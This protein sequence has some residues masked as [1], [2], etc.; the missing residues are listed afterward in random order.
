MNERKRF[1][2]IKLPKENE[3]TAAMAID[4]E[5]EQRGIRKRLLVWGNWIFV[6]LANQFLSQK[7]FLRGFASVSDV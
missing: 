5:R 1:E 2:R 3:G 7:D 4:G 6:G